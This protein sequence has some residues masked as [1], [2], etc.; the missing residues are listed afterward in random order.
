ML[1]NI[2]IIKDFQNQL[3][4][5][6]S[7]VP[8]TPNQITF[9]SLLFSLVGFFYLV[10][11]KF[12]K[13]FFFFLFAFLFDALD[14]AIARYKN[15]VSSRGAFLDGITDRI[16]EFNFLFGLFIIAE[17]LDLFIFLDNLDNSFISSKVLIFLIIVFGTFF[18]GY[19][20]AYA[21]HSKVLDHEKALLMP[22]LFERSE[23]VLFYI[24]AHFFLINAL[25]VF[26]YYI[27]LI[28]LVF[29]IITSLQRFVYV[30]TF[31]E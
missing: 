9:L 23:R 13:S 4:R 19:I 5:Y 24:I 22:G 16:V 11:F 8:L 20:K 7:I 18:P 21:E 26:F 10:N 17:F 12:L 15:L 29:S 31:N 6:L 25:Y 28:I 27:L 1:K 14:G 30:Y 2:K 3:G